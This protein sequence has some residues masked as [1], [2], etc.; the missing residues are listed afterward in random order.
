VRVQDTSELLV[1]VFVAWVL[2]DFKNRFLSWLAT[3]ILSD[4]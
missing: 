2:I 3:S 4:S 1:I